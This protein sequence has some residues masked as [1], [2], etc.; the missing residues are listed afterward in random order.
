M[1]QVA[2]VNVSLDLALEQT[3]CKARRRLA[4]EGRTRR[5]GEVGRNIEALNEL[6]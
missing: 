2:L 6:W 1:T 5:W 3:G 4:E